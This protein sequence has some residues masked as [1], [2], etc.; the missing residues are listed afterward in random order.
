MCPAGP[1]R[2]R[3]FIA[4]D[5][6]A[7]VR[8]ALHRLIAEIARCEADV[9]W[10]RV[11]T[12]HVTL[13][14]LGGVETQRLEAVRAA[15]A[16]A[17]QDRPALQLQVRGLGA[18]PSLHR[19]RVLWV[20]LHGDGVVELAAH[21]DAALARIGCEP[22]KR[23]FTPHATLGRVSSLRGWQRLEEAIQAHR[24]DDFGASTVD[25]VTI[26]RS[27]LR[28]DGAVYTPLWTISL[29]RNKEGAHHGIGR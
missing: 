10:V 9:R 1:E 26:Y 22:E 28:P 4:I 29:S 2:I 18:F 3:S 15:L 19:P 27:T 24:D 17:I 5:I 14:F 21:I 23:A 16:D 20:G 6:A 13:K 12:L 7:P 11:E 25:A 8:A